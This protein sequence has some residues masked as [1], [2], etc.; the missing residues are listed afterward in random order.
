MGVD[1]AG[2]LEDGDGDGLGRVRGHRG[3][4]CRGLCL[5]SRLSSRVGLSHR[6]LGFCLRGRQ[7]LLERLHGRGVYGSFG[8]F[9]GLHERGLS[10]SGG[11]SSSLSL[12]G[13]VLGL[14]LGSGCLSLSL[15]EGGRIGRARVLA[16]VVAARGRDEGEDKEGGK[17][18][19]H[20]GELLEH[21][22]ESPRLDPWFSTAAA[23]GIHS[24]AGRYTKS[25]RAAS[26]CIQPADSLSG[27]E[28]VSAAEP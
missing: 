15:L 9:L 16:L 6:G 25:Y 19:L 17:Q 23:Y 28:P 4:L 7:L 22:V 8:R 20:D 13:G 12:G 24:R 26:C 11:G 10:L 1:P 21:Q 27:R 3:G 5:G 14:G 18:P 2:P